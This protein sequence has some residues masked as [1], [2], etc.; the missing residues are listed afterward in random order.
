MK[1][2][3]ADGAF[4]YAVNTN[5]FKAKLSAAETVKLCVD[6]GA[7]G[8]EWGIKSLATARAEAREMHK[9]TSDAGLEVLGY[10]NAGR[11]WK[12]D[13]MRQWSEAVAGC[14]GKTLRVAHPWFGWDY[15]ES[16]RQREA[17]MDLVKRSVD[18]VRVLEKLSRE[19]GIKYVLETHSGSVAADPWAV[20]YLMQGVDPN[21]VGAIY[22][23]ANTV[24]EGFIRPRG[25]CELMG[26][27][28]A[29]LH[30]KN[31]V[32]VPRSAF[33]ETPAPSRMQ[34][35]TQRVFLNQGMVDF[36][37]VF[38]A[39]KCV[40]YAGWISLEDFVTESYVREISEGIAFLK[41]CATAAPDRPMEPF[42][43][44]ND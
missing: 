29:Y 33:V 14:G 41:E 42:T 12:E 8:I 24:V 31:L 26:R 7:D 25:A 18:A 37:E 16:L 20:R 35:K 3:N 9:L 40:G 17:Y 36:V 19:C 34:W 32:F 22:D 44:F 21:C 5:T 1:R 28:I 23:P 2:K 13:V 39:L 4:K 15:S 38:F 11:M 10:I 43:T 6:A 27:H 30:A